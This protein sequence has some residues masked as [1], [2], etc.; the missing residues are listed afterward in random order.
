VELSL[1]KARLELI[2]PMTIITVG[3]GKRN[4]FTAALVSMVS[5]FSDPPLLMV[6]VWKRNLSYDLIGERK[7]FAVNTICKDQIEI[8]KLFGAKSG[9][10]TDKFEETSVETFPASKIKAPLLKES[11]VNLECKV[12]KQIDSGDCVTFIA[13]VVAA[14]KNN[15]KEPIAWF[16]GKYTE[17][18]R[19]E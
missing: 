7:E 14:H 17:I 10:D 4:G 12:I 1:K 16:Q 18:G 6:S 3:D 8:A 19:R 11:P 2:S 15:D 5:A 9:R 13:E